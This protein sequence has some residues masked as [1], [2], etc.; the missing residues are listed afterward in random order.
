MSGTARI[1]H[2][3]KRGQ[4]HL[5][6]LLDVPFL[7]NGKMVPTK[8]CI[9]NKVHPCKTIHL[10]L[11]DDGGVLVSEGVLE[12]LKRSGMHDLEIVGDVAKA[13]T[14]NLNQTRTLVDKNNRAIKPLTSV[15]K[16]MPKEQKSNLR[17][18]EVALI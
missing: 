15:K 1:R 9:C 11:E 17:P 7:I 12:D 14:I 10:W 18:P 2:R 13:P 16:V 4:I 6:P 8:D 3:F 5:V